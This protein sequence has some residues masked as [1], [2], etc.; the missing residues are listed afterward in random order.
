MKK[1]TLSRTALA[2]QLG[3]T[4]MSRLR[5]LNRQSVGV[6][7]VPDIEL[8]VEA[9]LRLLKMDVRTWAEDPKSDSKMVVV[10]G[11]RMDTNEDTSCL[12]P[13]ILMEYASVLPLLAQL[14]Q[15]AAA[16]VLLW[17]YKPNS[18][19]KHVRMWYEIARYE[20]W[21]R[22]EMKELLDFLIANN[23]FE[24]INDQTLGLLY[25]IS[26]F[27]EL[28]TRREWETLRRNTLWYLIIG[29][30]KNMNKKQVEAISFLEDYLPGVEEYRIRDALKIV[31][32]VLIGR[33]LEDLQGRAMRTRT[34]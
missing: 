6:G 2:R 28:S 9:A 33:H 19:D 23:E 12:V 21:A 5:H 16:L 26:G 24:S 3:T 4:D 34:T 15:N 25:E 31:R 10:K 17:V 27:Q 22:Q 7:A 13:P 8:I 30:L 11:K 29:A 32:K 20:N 1:P 18:S 14:G